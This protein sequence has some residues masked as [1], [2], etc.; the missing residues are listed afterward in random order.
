MGFMFYV[1]LI[2]MIVAVIV[3][4]STTELTSFWFAIGALCALISN[5][6]MQ[7]EYI[8]LQITIFAV[9]SIASI[10]FFKPLVRRK[11]KI[12]KVATNVDALIGK[13]ALVTSSIEV[14]QPGSVK[15]EGIEWTAITVSDSFEP[16]DLVEIESVSGNTL[17]V[18]KK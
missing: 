5:L 13:I 17:L 10:L 3:E 6:F 15:A 7:N 4:I 2:V 18:R 11:M 9:I 12:P 8:W 16:G 1:W 14:N